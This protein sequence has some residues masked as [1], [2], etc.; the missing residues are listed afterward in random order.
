MNFKRSTTSMAL[1]LL[2]LSLISVTS[3]QQDAFAQSM[4]MTITA[5]A[6][7]GSDTISVSGQ[8]ASKVTDVTF[9]VTSPSGNN[10]VGI[11]QVSPDENGNFAKEFRVGPTWTENGFY[12][13]T[14]MQSVG[15]NSLYTMSVHVEV[16]NGMTA[17]TSVTNSNMETGIFKPVNNNTIERGLEIEAEALIGSTEIVITGTT[18]RVSQDVT[19]TVTAPNGNKVSVAQVSPSINGDFAK[20]IVTGGPL[21]KQDGFY[22]VTAKQFESEDYTKSIQVDIKEGVVV[23]EFGTIAVMILAV[24]IISIIAVSAK[25]R[26][27]IM[28]RY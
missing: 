13:I 14:A 19:L 12:K 8:T 28:P 7:K 1:A 3:I 21:W 17:K 23:P 27:S 11:G 10:V 20:T 24:A 5:T 6:A 16:K 2:A 25:S 18:D 26:L 22:T 4:G 15:S 9:R